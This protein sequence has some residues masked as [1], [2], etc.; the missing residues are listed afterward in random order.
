MALFAPVGLYLESEVAFYFFAAIFGAAS[1]GGSVPAILLRI[2]G[3]GQNLVSTFDGFEM[4]RQG[5][6]MEA[7]TISAVASMLGSFVSVVVLLLVLP[8]ARQIV[9]L[10]G[11]S[12]KFW[13]IMFAILMVPF[14]TGTDVIKGLVSAML[15]L[16]LS[17]IGR[18]IVTGEFRYTL[19]TIYLGN[20]LNIISFLIIGVFAVGVVFEMMSKPQQPIAHDLAKLE[21]RQIWTGLRYVLMRPLAV[22]RASVIGV[23]MGAIPGLGPTTASF[24]SYL[25]AKASSKTPEKFGT[26]FPDGL[27]APEAANNA[28]SGGAA[29]PSLFLA[30]PGDLSWA[31]MLGI[32]V[33]YGILPGPDLITEHPGL[34]W[35]VI[36]G[37]VVANVIASS[38]GLLAA[39]RLAR[40]TTI[41]PIYISAVLLTTCMVGAYLIHNNVWDSMTALVGGLLGYVIYRLNYGLLPFA[42][43]FILGPLIEKSFYLTVQVGYGTYSVFFGSTLSIILI[44]FCVAVVAVGPWLQRR[45]KTVNRQ[46][47]DDEPTNT[48]HLEI[49]HWGE[50]LFSLLTLVIGSF[51]VGASFS[52][53][54]ETALFAVLAG[55]G[56]AGLSLILLLKEIRRGLTSLKKPVIEKAPTQVG[57]R[58]QQGYPFIFGFTWC[59]G[60]FVAVLLIGYVWTV[61]IWLVFFLFWGRASRILTVVLSLVLWASVKFVLGQALGTLFFEGILFGGNVPRLW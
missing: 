20:G 34:I 46:A 15:G 59:A 39:I 26:G 19:G 10:F 55:S 57:I 51:V 8:F 14:I 13:L 6:A 31:I 58:D 38:I 23:I 29:I 50:V 30:I 17:F 47:T 11:P 52:Y 1:F 40:L 4:S 61:P 37:I 56:Q 33:M 49:L 24:A 44:V 18:S 9:F 16:V 7:L 43:G 22:I 2:P 54:L 48:P 53:R 41:K 28:T 21:I 60:F 25:A 35:G 45:L 5:R 12:E 3:S 27:L 42:L 36:W 32:L